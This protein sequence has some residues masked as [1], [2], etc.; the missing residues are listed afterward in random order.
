[1]P[2]P[3]RQEG[4]EEQRSP[5]KTLRGERKAA[6]W[7]ERRHP[8]H[9]SPKAGL[10]Q[11]LPPPPGGRPVPQWPGGSRE[12]MLGTLPFL[13]GGGFWATWSGQRVSSTRTAP[14]PGKGWLRALLKAR[15]RGQVTGG[16]GS[17]LVR[18][19][20]LSERVQA[21]PPTRG[22][23]RGSHPPLSGS[24]CPHWQNQTADTDWCFSNGSPTPP[25]ASSN[26]T[27]SGC[28]T[29][30]TDLRATFLGWEGL[31]GHPRSVQPPS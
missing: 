9:Q 28:P 5:G 11:R 20:K 8:P 15:R 26:K 25:A 27:V 7:W 4:R 31:P 1:M 2:G 3:D 29:Q 10:G 24:A 14:G 30:E 13:P 17:V 16:A 21:W 18:E 6:R 19:A 12:L 22:E 23:A